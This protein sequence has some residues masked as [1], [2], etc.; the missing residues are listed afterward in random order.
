MKYPKCAQGAGR[1]LIIDQ[2]RLLLV[3]GNGDGTFWTLPGGRSD[4]GEDIKSCVMREVLEETGL[5]VTVGSFFAA[6]EF[7]DESIGFHV[8]EMLFMATLADGGIPAN[9]TDHDG[10]IIE[11]RFFTLDE[12]KSLPF[13]APEFLRAGEWLHPQENNFYRGI[14][15][16]SLRQES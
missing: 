4:L 6:N 14:E 11:A 13:I 10:P 16:K 12:I 2:G 8:L 1:A 3:R 15:R 9:W 5:K 7:Y